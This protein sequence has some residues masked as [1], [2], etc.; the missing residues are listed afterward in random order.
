MTYA[1]AEELRESRKV[2][3]AG[4]SRPQSNAERS[5]ATTMKRA[6]AEIR[7]TDQSEP[8]KN[9]KSVKTSVMPSDWIVTRGCFG[10]HCQPNSANDRHR[11]EPCKNS[12]EDEAV[13][14]APIRPDPTRQGKI[15]RGHPG[16]RG[17][18]EP[19][20]NGNQPISVYGGNRQ[21]RSEQRHAPSPAYVGALATSQSKA[22]AM[23]TGPKGCLRLEEQQTCGG[24]DAQ[25]AGGRR[26]SEGTDRTLPIPT[27]TKSSKTR[28]PPCP[29]A[30]L[31]SAPARS[32]GSPCRPA[33]PRPSVR[34]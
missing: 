33:R 32:R 19:G 7:V 27:G 5:K 2:A 14:V 11:N 18:A 8:Q 1:A 24:D 10:K 4:D 34:C 20:Q 31:A 12:G 16:R 30:A 21:G 6:A 13:V 25:V 9:S 26:K 23:A 22:G 28:R 3:Q 17:P 15:Q 29:P